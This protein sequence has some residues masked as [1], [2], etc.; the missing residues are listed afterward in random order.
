[1]SHPAQLEPIFRKPYILGG[2]AIVTVVSK[3]SGERFTF[4]VNEKDV[5]SAEE[6][7]SLF[8]VSVLT[9]PENTRDYQFLGT[10]FDR[11]SFRHGQKS[12]IGAD[13]PS[14]RAFAW[15]WS[16]LDSDRF[17][18]WHEGRCSRCSR[19]LTDPDSIER[20]L[21]SKCAEKVAA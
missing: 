16:H 19:T 5:G 4:R 9:G 8:F 3:K 17:E 20:G 14:A 15:V 7:R 11:E 1:M 12:R 21:G 6:P 2:K 10:I 13:A 18:V